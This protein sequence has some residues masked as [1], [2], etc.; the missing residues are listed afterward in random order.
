[1]PLAVSGE[2]AGPAPSFPGRTWNGPYPEP[3]GSSPDLPPGAAAFSDTAVAPPPSGAAL[4][5][6]VPQISTKP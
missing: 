5:P 3:P 6:E 4:C 2:A 1:M